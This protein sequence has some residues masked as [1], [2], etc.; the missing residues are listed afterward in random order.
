MRLEIDGNYGEG[1]GQIL[2]SSLSLSAILQQ[3]IR[4]TNIRA[5]RKRSGLAA[6]HLTAVNAVAAITNAEVMGGSLGSQTL[7]FI[8]QEIRGGHY[9]FDVADI[10]P[11]AG[12]LSLVFQAIVLPLAHADAASTVTLR[13]GTHVPWSPNVHYLQR[14]FLPMAAKFGF[15]GSLTLNRW[16]WYPKG[17]GEAIAKIQPT[18]DWREVDLRSRGK[19]KAIHGIS[20]VSNLPDHILNRQR[21][22]CLKR[23]AQLDSPVNIDPVK[24]KS[25]GPGTLVFLK[26]EFE[27]IQAG[28]S[29]LGARGKRA[30][31]VADEACQ[32]L[33]DFLAS[34]AAIEPHLA[35]QLIL[36]MALA[37]GESRFTTSRITRH[38]TTNIWLVQQFLPVKFEVN[39]AEGEPGEIVKHGLRSDMGE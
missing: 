33:Q 36:P 7:T 27:N 32:E 8:P 12:S 17:G 24:G 9:T 11:S 30:E 22:Q 10:R 39:G 35:D 1:G 5:G 6:Q 19:L 23:L 16:G 2:R 25:I 13:G 15:H 21:N 29:A 4:I 3:P 20:A 38:L 34:D 31:Q 26:A 28:F 37:K 14:I 18:S